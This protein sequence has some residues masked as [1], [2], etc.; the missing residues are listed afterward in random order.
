MLLD[1]FFRDFVFRDFFFR[2]FFLEIFFRDFFFRYFGGVPRF[3]NPINTNKFLSQFDH[4]QILTF[5][6]FA[7]VQVTSKIMGFEVLG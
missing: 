4:L 5:K 3:G 7:F 2:D 1:I 6:R